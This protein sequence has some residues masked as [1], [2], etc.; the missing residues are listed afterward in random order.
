RPIG[1]N[2]LSSRNP[3]EYTDE[4]DP[5]D[6][7]FRSGGCGPYEPANLGLQI[8]PPHW[9]PVESAEAILKGH[10][11]G[12]RLDFPIP[13]DHSPDGTLEWTHFLNRHHF[14]RELVK[15]C[16][17][18]GEA[19]YA[20]AAAT[21]IDDWITASPVPLDSNGGAGPAWETLSVAWRLREWLWVVGIAWRHPAFPRETKIKMLCSVWE[22]ARSLMDHQGHPN[23][24]IMVE[25]AALAL[26]GM[27]FSGFREAPDRLRE[28][29]DRLSHQIALQFF[30]DGVHFEISPMYHAI[31]I[32]ALLEVK[33]AA[34]A[35][36]VP[37]PR[38]LG[39]TVR[40]GFRYLAAL[41]RPD[42]TWPSINDSGSACSDYTGL[43]A[44]AGDVSDQPESAWIGS[45]GTRGR[46]PVENNTAFPDAGIVTMRSGYESDANMLV[47][48]CGP[49][50]AF[51]AHEDV[52]SLDVTACGLPRV[53]DPG[54][55]EY[56]PGP[57]TQYYRSAQAHSMILINEAGPDRSS[58]GYAGKVRPAG[59][60]LAFGE[61]E[62]IIAAAGVSRGPWK[63]LSAGGAVLRTVFFVK[64]EYWIIRDVI[65]ARGSHRI[66][67]SW[68][69]FP[70][71]IE[72]GDG[73]IV[74]C[75]DNLGKGFEIIPANPK[76]GLEVS[77]AGG[78]LTPPRGWI[79][80]YH[81]D[82]P[83]TNV[84]YSRLTDL[85]SS[86]V[87]VLMP[88]TGPR[89]SGTQVQ[90]TDGMDCDVEIVIRCGD[91]FED[92]LV[93]PRTQELA[94]MANSPARVGRFTFRRHTPL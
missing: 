94:D 19:R 63:G 51:H 48:R 21:M 87:W 67:T 29:L 44:W 93:I 28:G 69:L 18:T 75:S 36:S 22:H 57:L 10:I 40:G 80:L 42:F 72:M 71:P 88:H 23:N 24:W 45:R 59:S 2:G 46:P 82:V 65:V 7:V 86:A 92:S 66:T 84:C 47:F 12:E 56:R 61:F 34:D 35:L 62:E 32:H 11:M 6:Q 77:A 26:T 25:S 30:R 60:D 41:C 4:P 8:P 81:R 5:I 58:L 31:C 50:S 33:H 38:I 17:A 52:L 74:R 20:E 9:Y 43:S 68:N 37:V 16:A 78:L 39:E 13:W 76:P 64:R 15:A 85:P 1:G 14:I 79:S 27:C 90:C 55:G 49:P 91:S 70:G 3:G 53:C 83:C 73:R 54:M 89:G